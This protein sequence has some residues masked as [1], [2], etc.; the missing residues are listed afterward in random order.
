MILTVTDPPIDAGR[1][2]RI[3][4]LTY[5]AAEAYI[6]LGQRLLNARGQGQQPPSPV[7]AELD[8]VSEHLLGLATHLA[9]LAEALEEAR[10]DASSRPR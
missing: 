5:R 10:G 3:A 2:R 8:Q 4:G 9:R 1:I 7:I 6:M